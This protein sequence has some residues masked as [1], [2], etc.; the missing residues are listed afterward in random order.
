MSA[1]SN[2]PAAIRAFVDLGVNLTNFMLLL[3]HKTCRGSGRRL[4]SSHLSLFGL[5]KTHDFSNECVL[6]RVTLRDLD[7]FRGCYRFDVMQGLEAT[8]S[9]VCTTCTLL[10]LC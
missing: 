9:G 7:H 3:I 8:K 6:L 10:I 2:G 1:L 5:L 4:T